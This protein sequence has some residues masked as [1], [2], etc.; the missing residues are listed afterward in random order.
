[1]TFA[2]GELKEFILR[3]THGSVVVRNPQGDEKPDLCVVR[4]TE[5]GTSKPLGAKERFNV[6]ATKERLR[7]RHR[8]NEPKLRLEV[9]VI[10][11]KGVNVDVGVRDGGIRLEGKF[12]LATATCTSGDVIADPLWAVGGSLKT[13][14]G[15]VKVVL[16]ESTLESNLS[17]E[18]IEGEV[19]LHIPLALRGPVH[20]YSG[21]SEID[22]GEE[23]KMV[24]RLDPE[25]KN[26]RGVAGPLMT[27]DQVEVAKRSGRW[28]PGVWAKSGKGKVIFRQD[29]EPAKTNEPP[30]PK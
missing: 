18:T 22:Y 15:K 26:A 8:R 5:T 24:L 10:V 3:I 4:V 1:M 21:S 12:G 7:L 11:P 30:E 29:G 25:R 13:L 14:E 2:G 17:C 16:K 27:Q 23:P 20:L 19:A 9:L 28:P 6:S